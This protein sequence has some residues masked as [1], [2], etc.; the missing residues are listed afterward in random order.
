MIELQRQYSM[1][2]ADERGANTKDEKKEFDDN[3]ET[4]SDEDSPQLS[5]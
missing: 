3:V 1:R 2:Q 4:E 5:E